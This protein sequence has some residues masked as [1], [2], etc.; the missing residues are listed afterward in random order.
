M[1]RKSTC[2][3]LASARDGTDSDDRFTGNSCY[4]SFPESPISGGRVSC[5]PVRCRHGESV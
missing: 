5:Y 2:Q 4:L 3:R 1:R